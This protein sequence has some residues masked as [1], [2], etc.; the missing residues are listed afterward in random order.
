MA[1]WQINSG[2]SPFMPRDAVGYALAL[3]NTY[4]L[5][6]IDPVFSLGDK[7]VSAWEAGDPTYRPQKFASLQEAREWCEERASKLPQFDGEITG[8][9]VF[10]A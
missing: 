4:C 8:R 9:D 1:K 2:T 10:P 7:A 3:E 5:A 6:T